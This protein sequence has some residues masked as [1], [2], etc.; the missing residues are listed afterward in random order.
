M[1]P[2]DRLEIIRAKC[3]PVKTTTR[4]TGPRYGLLPSPVGD[5]PISYGIGPSLRADDRVR[6]WVKAPDENPEEHCQPKRH[7]GKH[8]LDKI[9]DKWVTP[10]W[11]EETKRLDLYHA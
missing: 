1:N 9:A 7:R 4:A 10:E 2:A 8:H 5:K 3:R 6:A 11:R